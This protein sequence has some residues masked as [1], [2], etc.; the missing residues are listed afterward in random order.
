M[1]DSVAVMRRG[2]NFALTLVCT[3]S[4]CMRRASRPARQQRS[5]DAV[6]FLITLAVIAAALLFAEL[7]MH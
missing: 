1:G 3:Y 2:H 6:I 4:A 5:S 7:M